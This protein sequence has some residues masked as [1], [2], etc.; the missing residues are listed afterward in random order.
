MNFSPS[1][2]A[3]AV[4]ASL[5]LG[6]VAGVAGAQAAPSPPQ[7]A[8]S[9]PQAAA[10]APQGDAMLA[11]IK[12]TGTAESV[13]RRSADA[14]V[15][16]DRPLVDTPYSINVIGRTLIDLQQAAHY[17]DY[18]KNDPSATVGNVPVGFTTLRGFPVGTA[19]Y[20]YDGLPGN[21]GIADGR[22]QLEGVDRIEVLK[23][24]SAFLYGLGSSTSLG[25]TYNYVPKKPL[26]EPVRSATVGYTSRSLWSVT[27]DLGDRFGAERQFGWRFNAGYRDGEQAVRD[28]DWTHKA[29]TI[30][31]DWRAAPGLL[32]TAGAEYANNH[33][34]RLQPFYVLSPGLAVPVAP[35]ASR[36]MSQPWDDFRTVATSSWLRAD[37][38][39]AP[40]W[41]VT[42]QA[43][44][45]RSARPRTRQARF[46]FITSEAGDTL[47]FTAQN[48]SISSAR[49]GQVLLRGKLTT[50]PLSH[51]LTLGVT[52]SRDESRSG[53]APL[54]TGATP[55]NLYTPVDAP[56]PAAVPFDVMPDQ[57]SRSSSIL[58]SDI[59]AFSEQW[60]VLV[61]VRR[62]KLALTNFGAT[63]EESSLSK[64]S[65]TAALMWKPRTSALVYLNYA[66][67]L[68]QGGQ[69]TNT[70]TRLP[71]IKTEQIELGAK[72]DLDALALTAA[73]FDLRKPL[74]DLTAG[75]QTGEQRHR[76]IELVANGRVHPDLTLVA[77][78]MWL[79]PTT[80][81]TAS[82]ATEGRRPAGVA[83]FT[84][85]LWADWRLAALPGLY[86]NA[87]VFHSGRQFLDNANTQAV[88]KWTRFDA[89]ARYET[90]VGG[91]RTVYLLGIE[92]LADKKYWAG[93]QSG[94]LTLAEPRTLKFTARF[95]L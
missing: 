92:N 49:A 40:E 5:A 83:Q 7:A 15:L 34:P 27:T 70:T 2:I 25:G 79:D 38:Q 58:L 43:M 72:L 75:T 54:G 35:D 53:S 80:R 42:A 47:L 66:E 88:P 14:G 59:V 32:F 90:R 65:P 48:E 3:R 12:A 36:N 71:P 50:G 45:S 46:G 60:S 55:S 95:D 67:G 1:P 74:E 87:G 73:L 62:A 26:D 20:L 23:G 29:A 22:W 82:A 18:L 57:K 51:Q 8:A 78:S 37:W 85:N 11:P 81:G 41:S 17:G 93:A 19:G 33:F 69:I 13:A 64:T 10:S 61:G 21:A 52:A 6:S 77:G 16:G 91:L 63:T 30:A 86:L 84:A 31:L 4:A 9:A 44:G 68:E 24:P 89:G 39:I 56:E 28:Y 76:G 94:L